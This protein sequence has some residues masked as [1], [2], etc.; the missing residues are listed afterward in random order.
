MSRDPLLYSRA[1]LSGS[2]DQSGGLTSL[3]TS[4]D[5]IPLHLG[6]ARLRAIRTP[7][8]RQKDEKQFLITFLLNFIG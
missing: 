7:E 8:D 5:K 3:G 6:K 1:G 4:K 2:L